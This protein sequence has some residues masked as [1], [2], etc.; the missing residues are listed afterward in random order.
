MLA[1]GAGANESTPLSATAQPSAASSPA[2]PSLGQLPGNAD[3]LKDRS[4]QLAKSLEDAV[5]PPKAQHPQ[6]PNSG[7][8]GP[9]P[10]G[11][12]SHI[13]G[14]TKT[15]L[16][17]SAG[18]HFQEVTSSLA[19]ASTQASTQASAEVQ[20]NVSSAAEAV[21]ET[22]TSSGRSL[23]SIQQSYEQA[24]SGSLQDRGAS[25]SDVVHSIQDAVAGAVH[26]A[27]DAASSAVQAAQDALQTANSTLSQVGQQ[28]CHRRHQ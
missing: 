28:C 26:S 14:T 22:A 1:K 9:V 18:S 21:K 25:S 6:P 19:D 7:P 5:L 4:S 8:T 2:P 27:Q 12:G 16:R 10:S 24:V 23:E 17:P 11:Q 13:S 3:Q 20:D 15:A